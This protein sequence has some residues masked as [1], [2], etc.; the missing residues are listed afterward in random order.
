MKSV[1]VCHLVFAKAYLHWQRIFLRQRSSEQTPLFFRHCP[2]CASFS[3]IIFCIRSFLFGSLLITLKARK[4]K[5]Y[6]RLLPYINAAFHSRN[7]YRKIRLLPVFTERKTSPE[8]YFSILRYSVS[9][10]SFR[11]KP[12]PAVFCKPRPVSLPGSLQDR[13]SGRF[14]RSGSC[15][16]FSLNNHGTLA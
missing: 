11:R 14:W 5:Q 8:T 6:G 15:C 12:Q 2:I 3:A 10:F 1:L 13:F 9:N 16:S 4:V 7:L